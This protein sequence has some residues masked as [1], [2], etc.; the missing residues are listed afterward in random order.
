MSGAALAPQDWP[1]PFEVSGGCGCGGVRFRVHGKLRPPIACHCG[2]C[3]RASGHFVVA[4][5]A[6]ATDATITGADAITWYRS[7]DIADR[8]FCAR[9]GSQL[10]Y[11]P[12]DRKRLSIMMGVL[13][14]PHPPELRLAAHIFTGDRAMYY[15]IAD[16]CPQFA[17]WQDGDA[18]AG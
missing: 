16:G 3:Q 6:L 13:D 9:C 14:R 18:R 17:M 1:G 11:R 15:D 5:Q 7:S 8:G 12:H 10:F 4:T 2:Q